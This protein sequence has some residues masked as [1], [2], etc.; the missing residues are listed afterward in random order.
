MFTR[1]LEILTNLLPNPT[2]RTKEWIARLVALAVI[3][4][5]IG[6]IAITLLRG[7]ELGERIGF[8]PI[9]SPLPQL[10]HAQF[11]S[12]VQQMWQ[13]ITGL[14]EKNADI[15]AT[16]VIVLTDKKTGNIVT[17]VE[18]ERTDVLI[19]VWSIPVD[20][21]SSLDIFTQ[22]FNDLKPKLEPRLKEVGRCLSGGIEKPV[23]DFLKRGVNDFQS[24]HFSICPIFTRRDYRLVAATVAFYI[25][26][27]NGELFYYE[28]QLQRS[29]SFIASKFDNF[30]T[31]HRFIYN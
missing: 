7:T 10:S 5:T 15:R 14:R 11:T 13:E 2:L 26:P 23:H 6:V 8:N 19:W 28:D 12:S 18:Q 27:D 21:F 30:A 17:S 16:F 22:A 3:A 4:I 25:N 20:K 29:T 31:P 1:V 9:S 24:T